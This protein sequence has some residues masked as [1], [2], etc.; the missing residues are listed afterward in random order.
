MINLT[1][2]RA[3][4]SKR[5]TNKFEPEGYRLYSR[6]VRWRSYKNGRIYRTV[7]MLT[8]TVFTKYAVHHMIKWLKIRLPY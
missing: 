3:I 5:E 2:F 6:R 1:L 4:L 8:Y 7:K